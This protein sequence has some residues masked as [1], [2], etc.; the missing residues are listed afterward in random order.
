MSNV[1]KSLGWFFKRHVSL[2]GISN[3]IKYFSTSNE[4]TQVVKSLV[5]LMTT[6]LDVV[7]TLISRKIMSP[8]FLVIRNIDI[9]V[10][11]NLSDS[12]SKRALLLKIIKLV[13]ITIKMNSI[14][15]RALISY[16][17]QE[18]KPSP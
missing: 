14:L 4:N 3:S 10:F 16:D 7:I 11:L 1:A 8:T 9:E 18:N 2:P 6:C 15:G 17:E 5:H 12:A 13:L